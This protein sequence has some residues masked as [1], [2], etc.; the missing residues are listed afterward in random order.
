MKKISFKPKISVLKNVSV[1]FVLI[2][3]YSCSK[4][5]V[6]STNEESTSI[7]EVTARESNSDVTFLSGQK[8]FYSSYASSVS[9]LR[10]LQSSLCSLIDLSGINSER[11]YLVFPDE[12]SMQSLY[13][14]I[15]DVD[16]RFQDTVEARLE[17]LLVEAKKNPSIVNYYTLEAAISNDVD[18]E[19]L[20]GIEE[21]MWNDGVFAEN[22]QQCV[23][24]RMPIPTL[25]NKVKTL[26]DNWLAASGEDLDVSKDPSNF[27]IDD[28]IA[29]LFL[30]ED[31]QASILGKV[32][33][34]TEDVEINSNNGGSFLSRA[35]GCRTWRKEVET[36]NNGS[37]RLR[38]VAKVR[39]Y[40]AYKIIKSKITGWKRRRGRWKK[41]RFTKTLFMGGIAIAHRASLDE[42]CDPAFSFNISLSETKKKKSFRISRTWWGPDWY[43]AVCRDQFGAVG[44]VGSLN[45][46]AIID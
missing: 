13:E 11:G 1:L 17:E 14:A 34:F 28:E 9:E 46:T 23:S 43:V 22:I 29:S 2:A 7:N 35:N 16:R 38:V 36:G 3:I 5:S 33:T 12:R 4:D 18:E 26:S 40:V 42:N 30:N 41:R 32:E 27:Y 15:E 24:D 21:L 45:V 37:R 8:T 19:I 10:S 20:N 39:N 31:S 25:W 6:E 44:N